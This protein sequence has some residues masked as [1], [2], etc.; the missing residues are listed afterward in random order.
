MRCYF[1]LVNSHEELIDDEGVEVSDLE[2]AKVQAMQAVSEL[3]RE[4]GGGI[5]DWSGWNLHIVCP[6]GTLLHS[7]PLATTLH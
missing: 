3:Q 1:H 5:E 4:Y 6:E 7:I 2:S